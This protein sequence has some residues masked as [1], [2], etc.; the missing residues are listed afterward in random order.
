MQDK[1]Q[2]ILKNLFILDLE[3]NKMKTFFVNFFAVLFFL[4]CDFS[5]SQSKP[6]PFIKSAQVQC[7]VTFNSQTKL[8]EYHYQIING[9][10]SEGNITDFEIDILRKPGS[11]TFDTTNLRFATR[12]IENSFRRH[13]PLL[14]DSIVSVGFPSVPAFWTAMLS[15]RGRASFDGD[16]RNDIKPGK[17]LENY[18]ISSSGF[19]Q[20]RSFVLNAYYDV[21]SFY[22]SVDE[23][24]NPDSLTEKID[25][26]RESVKFRGY[27]IGPTAPPINFVATEWCDTLLSYIRQSAELGWLKSKRDDDCDDDEKPEDGVTGNLIKR[28]QKIQTFLTKG[29]SVKARN[30]LEKFLKKVEKIYSRSVKAEEKRKE[31]IIMTSECYALLK[32]NGEY[33][34]D[35]LPEK[36][37]GGKN[38]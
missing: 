36:E 33:L 38:K 35:R 9:S 12:F 24:E 5:Y 18:V 20:I 31:D 32:Y 16:D 3:E 11:V 37:K 28:L 13:F 8:Y 4:Y 29:D 19:P 7:V 15:D 21:S 10:T 34:L 22:P 23:V 2:D 14:A 17:S 30:E 26:D 25:Y 6:L 1:V 27:T